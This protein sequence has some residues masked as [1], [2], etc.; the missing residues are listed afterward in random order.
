MGYF[1]LD[2]NI[3]VQKLATLTLGLCVIVWTAQFIALPFDSDLVPTATPAFGPLFSNVLVNY[4][5][6]M[7]VPSWVNEKVETVSVGRTLWSSSAAATLCYLI[8]GI[9]GGYALDI[10][11]GVSVAWW[12]RAPLTAARMTYSRRSRAATGCGR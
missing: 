7:T 8:L 9:L 11:A 6:V 1:N 5:Y 3:W 10:Q 12:R 4:A 2:D